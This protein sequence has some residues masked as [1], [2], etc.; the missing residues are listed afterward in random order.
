VDQEPVLRCRSVRFTTKT[1]DGSRLY[2][3]NRLVIDRWEGASGTEITH[4][5]DLARALHSIRMEYYEGG[6]AA[7]AR[8][9]WNSTVDQPSE[10]YHAEYWNA[11]GLVTFAIPATAPTLA[12]RAGN[13]TSGAPVRRHRRS[14]S[15][16]SSRGGPER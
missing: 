6:G 11:T 15:T 7:L 10:T 2:I 13:T 9:T 4:T 3:D 1:D 16:S 8:L 14:R 5:V 12:R